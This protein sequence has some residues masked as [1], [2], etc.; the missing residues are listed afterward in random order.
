MPG[1]DLE[2][3]EDFLKVEEKLNYTFAARDRGVSPSTLIR[4]IQS[5][6]SWLGAPLLEKGK[7][8]LQLTDAGREFAG[9]ARKIVADL[10]NAKGSVAAKAGQDTV[11]IYTLHTLAATFAPLVMREI[12]TQLRDTEMDIRISVL[13]GNLTECV[14]AVAYGA[15]P[16]MLSYENPRREILTDEFLQ[17]LYP[18]E[19]PSVRKEKIQS[20][21][22]AKDRLIPVCAKQ[23]LE[24]YQRMLQEGVPIPCS[25]YAPGTYLSELVDEKIKELQ[26]KDRVKPVHD[27][28]MADTLRNLVRERQGIAWVLLSTAQRALQAED[29][30]DRFDF[31]LGTA[32]TIDLEIKLFHAT[33][34]QGEIVDRIW[35]VASSPSLERALTP[36]DF[37]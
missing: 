37:I 34:H 8:P 19:E 16:F 6:E 1:P 35:S 2:W 32:A 17:A 33:N 29:E 14:E 22:I 10:G 27:A 21:R 23:N 7:V 36:K 20:T 24:R 11:R 30:L 31:N 3:L 28:Q 4:R 12:A 13:V 18:N 15:A 9:D 25:T 26:L 5:L